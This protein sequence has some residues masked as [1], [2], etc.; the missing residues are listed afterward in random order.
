ML[1]TVNLKSGAFV[2]FML[3]NKC[4]TWVHSQKDSRLDFGE[5]FTLTDGIFPSVAE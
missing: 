5:S 1:N 4:L 2:V 3:L